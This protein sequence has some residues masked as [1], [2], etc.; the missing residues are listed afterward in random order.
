MYAIDTATAVALRPA[1]TPVGPNPLAWFTDGN[2]GAGQ[3]ATILPAEW[4]NSQQAEQ[5]SLLGAAGLTP[6]KSKSDQLL[7]AIQAIVKAAAPAAV[8]VGSA[9]QRD[10]VILAM[11]LARTKAAAIQLA[12][13]IDD[14]FASAAGI[15]AGRSSGVTTFA[16][17]TPSYVKVGSPPSSSSTA[18]SPMTSANAPMGVVSATPALQTGSSAYYAFDQNSATLARP[19]G[20]NETFTRDLGAAATI[21]GYA[22]TD[23]GASDASTINHGWAPANLV[24]YGSNDGV[25]WTQ[26]DSQ[27]L[28]WAN[29]GTTG[30][31]TNG[32]YKTRKV[33]TLANSVNY[34]YFEW[35]FTGGTTAT[36][37]GIIELELLTTTS[38]VVTPGKLD[39]AQ[40]IAASTPTQGAIWLIVK[41]A[42]A[43]VLNTDISAKLS[44]N[45]GA[46]LAA[47]PLTQ[48]CA[49]SDGTVFLEATGVDLTGQTAGALTQMRYEIDTTGTYEIDVQAV[50]FRWS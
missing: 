30:P 1:S 6:D 42:Q 38:A 9:L 27:A 31:D 37:A 29:S 34:R 24:F 14:T 47:A 5:L 13:G 19:T 11:Q 18:G 20:A 7:T 22:V 45:D 15:D 36:N 28:N 48:V 16:A 33:F 44:R 23:G 8:P 35:A 26:L 10:V 12:D 2:P 43:M 3:P 39:S 25:N 21:N 49:F 41:A 40:F 17:A 4:L 46:N 50:V 32:F